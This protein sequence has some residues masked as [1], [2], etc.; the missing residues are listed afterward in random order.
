LFA[1]TARIWYRYA[2]PMAV[3]QI[4]G[5]IAGTRLAVAKGNRFVR[6][7]FL[8]VASALIARFGWQIFRP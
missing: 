6:L 7:L 2:I 1:F 4:A 8:V 3:C 5:S